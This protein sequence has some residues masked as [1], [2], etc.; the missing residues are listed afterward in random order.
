MTD[1]FMLVETFPDGMQ[2]V[3]ERVASEGRNLPRGLRLVD[4][5]VD[6]SLNR[7]FQL[8]ET[9]DRELLDEWMASWADLTRFEVVPVITSEEAMLRSGVEPVRSGPRRSG[10]PTVRPRRADR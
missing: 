5:W 8:M 7:C 1:R 10:S 9:D 4:S 6:E 3:Y 2:A